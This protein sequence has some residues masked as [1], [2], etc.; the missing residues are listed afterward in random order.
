MCARSSIRHAGRAVRGD[1]PRTG[2]VLPPCSCPPMPL[3]RS[4]QGARDT[5]MCAVRRHAV[6]K[7]L[8]AAAPFSSAQSMAASLTRGRTLLEQPGA[9]RPG[10]AVGI[11]PVPSQP[12]TG[13][14]GPTEGLRPGRGSRWRRRNAR[15]SGAHPCRV[16]CCS[17]PEASSSV[18]RPPLPLCEVA[19][20]I[21]HR[22]EELRPV[23]AGVV[24]GRPPVAAVLPA[25]SRRRLTGLP[26][27]MDECG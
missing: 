11:P 3:F 23:L 9:E 26:P 12:R 20:R 16:A 6:G 17:A 27:A 15:R 21:G 8:K 19:H 14:G 24:V 4:V 5:S 2:A 22:R 1:T 25:P 7:G 13:T 10:A 18:P